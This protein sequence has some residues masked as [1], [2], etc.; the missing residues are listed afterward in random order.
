MY[1]PPLILTL[2]MEDAFQ[3]Y[4]STLRTRHFPKH[5]NYLAAHITLFHHLPSGDEM[6]AGL[7]PEICNRKAFEMKVSGVKN[8]GNGVAFVIDSPELQVLHKAMQASFRPWL[9]SQDRHTLWPHITVQNK[10]TAFKAAQTAALLQEAFE[11]FLMMA[12]G[13]QSWLYRGGPWEEGEEWEFN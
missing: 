3:E 13:I 8:I 12:T 7:M 11:P 2:K 9:I 4:F 5:A 6:V 10:V 1:K